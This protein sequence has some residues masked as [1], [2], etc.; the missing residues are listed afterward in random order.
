MARDE[1]M[2][3][4]LMRERAL[5]ERR[6]D[7]DR[8]KQVDEQLRYYQADDEGS[9]GDEP[10]GRTGPEAAQRTADSGAGKPAAKKTA[11][12]K[13]AAS[14]PPAEPTTEQPAPPST[15]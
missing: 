1:N 14:K 10:T 11:A 9:G 5:Y 3:A 4:A 7:D 6:G 8:L 15:E 13:T 2:I 12:K